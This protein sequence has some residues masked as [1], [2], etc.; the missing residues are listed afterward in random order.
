MRSFKVTITNYLYK[1]LGAIHSFNGIVHFFYVKICG[2]PILPTHFRSAY[3]R[4]PV[5]VKQISYHRGSSIFRAAWIILKLE[6]LLEAPTFSQK[7][8]FRIPSCL[9]QILLPNNYS[10]ITNTLSDQLLLEE[11]YFFSTATASE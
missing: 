10:F 1:I 3:F 9:E 4:T 6:Q 2:H 5:T 11:N 7:E 8:F